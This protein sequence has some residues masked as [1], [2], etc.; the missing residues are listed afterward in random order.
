VP[1][2]R[3]RRY[4]AA[5][6]KQLAHIEFAL[7][8]RKRIS[9]NAKPPLEAVTFCARGTNDLCSSFASTVWV[10]NGWADYDCQSGPASIADWLKTD[11]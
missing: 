6:L 4:S 8:T 11:F 3:I 10:L 5:T 7:S 2:I 9:Y 1:L